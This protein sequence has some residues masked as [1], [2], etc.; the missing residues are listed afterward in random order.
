M[1]L[2]L[3]DHDQPGAVSAAVVDVAAPT[4]PRR[5]PSES[6]RSRRATAAVLP[7]F[8]ST[9]SLEFAKRADTRCSARM[10]VL[11]EIEPEKGYFGLV[12]WVCH[13]ANNSGKCTCGGC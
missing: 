9:H 1:A 12:R 7:R 8:G 13:K 11:D 2:A 6:P 5:W 4:R 10:R 3:D